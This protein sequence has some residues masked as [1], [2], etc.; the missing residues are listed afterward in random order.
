MA[1]KVCFVCLIDI[2]M[3]ESMVIYWVNM[4]ENL[5][6]LCN[7]LVWDIGLFVVVEYYGEVIGCVLLYVYDLGLVEICLLGV[8]VGW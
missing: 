4:G 3:L 6:C 8:E 1:V 5:F 2:E 7:E